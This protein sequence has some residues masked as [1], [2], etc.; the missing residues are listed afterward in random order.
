[1]SDP[2]ALSVIDY[3]LADSTHSPA[4]ALERMGS[5]TVPTRMSIPRLVSAAFI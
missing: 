2:Q 4:A 3:W 1:M 5:G